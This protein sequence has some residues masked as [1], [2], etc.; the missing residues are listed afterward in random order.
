[1]PLFEEPKKK[2]VGDALAWALLASKAPQETTGTSWRDTGL[3]A[4]LTALYSTGGASSASGEAGGGW[5]GIDAS[6]LGGIYGSMSPNELGSLAGFGPG[7]GLANLGLGL[8]GLPG[9]GPAVGWGSLGIRAAEAM[10]GPRE[11]GYLGMSPTELQ[12]IADYYGYG[13]SP[14]QFGQY[15][16]GYGSWGNPQNESWG[17]VMGGGAG[18][19]RGTDSG[20]SG[21]PGSGESSGMGSGT[22]GEA[23]GGAHY[24]AP[25]RERVS[26]YGEAGPEMGIF[27]PAFMRRPG[28]QGKEQE[29]RSALRRALLSLR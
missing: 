7:M 2:G 22:T 8:A 15:G 13:M 1:M 28:L 10:L 25:G 6:D 4:A 9:F 19:G 26:L 11:R 5:G 24:A 27:V 12:A 20:P 29:V 16:P 21:G 3:P 17:D 14:G 18:G 23:L